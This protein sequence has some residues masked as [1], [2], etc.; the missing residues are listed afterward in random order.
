MAERAFLKRLLNSY[1]KT[2]HT[3]HTGRHDGEPG[4]G[5]PLGEPRLM[6]SLNRDGECDESLR[7]DRDEAMGV[8]TARDRQ[9]RREL[10]AAGAPA[11][12]RGR[13]AGPV[14]RPGVSAR[15]H[16]TAPDSVPGAAPAPGVAAR[17]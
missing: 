2:W 17:R 14:R 15:H 11:A 9:R 16:S 1:G 5:L 6:W 13:D 12:R 3:W 4:D 7:R 10:G 8:D